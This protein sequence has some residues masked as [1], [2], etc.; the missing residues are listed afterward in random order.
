MTKEV[1]R[2]E[3][4]RIVAG[5]GPN[6]PNGRPSVPAEIRALLEEASVDAVRVIIDLVRC[7]DPKWSYPA[8]TQILDRVMGKPPSSPE[9]REAASKVW[10][11]LLAQKPPEGAG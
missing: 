3:K 7:G 10:A 6:N 5:S 1:K 2:D 8:A 4:G 11:A 9:E